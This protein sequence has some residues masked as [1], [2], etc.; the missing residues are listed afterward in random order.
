M[1]GFNGMDDSDLS[2]VGLNY[3]INGHNLRLNV[4]YTTGDANLTG[5]PG[6]DVSGL[7]IGLQIQ[8]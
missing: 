7:S 2:E 6:A 5:A 8:I 1:P 4:N 3:I